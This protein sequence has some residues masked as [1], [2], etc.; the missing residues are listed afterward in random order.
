M[1]YVLATDRLYL[2]E[3]T[4]DDIEALSCVLCDAESMKYYPKAF[5]RDEV[6][7]WVGKNIARYRIFGYGLWGVVLKSTNQL[8]GDCGIT[9]QNIDSVFLPELG[10]HIAPDFCRQGYATEA[11]KGALDYSHAEFKLGTVF[12]Y[13][14]ANNVPSRKTMERIGMSFFKEYTEQKSPKVAYRMVY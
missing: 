13:C 4:L 1:D 14:D 6:E 11:S 2:R 10:F 12:S 8:I 3:L 5:S 7:R 9:I